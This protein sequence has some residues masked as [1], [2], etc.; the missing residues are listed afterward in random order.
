MKILWA[1][2]DFTFVLLEYKKGG[3]ISKLKLKKGNVLDLYEKSRI[4]YITDVK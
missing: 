1:F 3:I 4:L 2:F